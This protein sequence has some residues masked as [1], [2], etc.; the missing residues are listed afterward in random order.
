MQHDPIIDLEN[1]SNADVYEKR[2]ISIIRHYGEHY[3]ASVMERYVQKRLMA[4]GHQ[5]TEQEIMDYVKKVAEGL[6]DANG[7]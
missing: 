6:D 3:A 1:A 2:L 5:V 7:K 4:S